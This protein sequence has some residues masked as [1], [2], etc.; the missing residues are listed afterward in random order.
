MLLFSLLEEKN[1]NNSAQ[2]GKIGKV[3]S[4]LGL[5]LKFSF[6]FRTVIKK[7]SYEFHQLIP[8]KFSLITKLNLLFLSTHEGDT[9]KCIRFFVG[10]SETRKEHET[11]EIIHCSQLHRHF[12]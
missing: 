5:S 4:P 6:A 8:K 10:F 11:L 1:L 7:K 9:F 2:Q 12:V 3:G